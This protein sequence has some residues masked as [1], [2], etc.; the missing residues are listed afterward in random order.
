MSAKVEELI[1][2]IAT[3][4]RCEL[5]LRDTSIPLAPPGLHVPHTTA[6]PLEARLEVVLPPDM[7][8]FRE[9][10]KKANIF[11]H[12]VLGGALPELNGWDIWNVEYWGFDR[13]LGELFFYEPGDI[14]D[15]LGSCYR[16]ANSAKDGAHHIAVDLG[17]ERYGQII[18]CYSDQVTHGGNVPVIAKSF[19]EWLERTLDAGPLIT[20][21]YWEEPGF[22]D[23]GSA[24]DGDPCYER[25][26]I[27]PGGATARM[28]EYKSARTTGLVGGGEGDVTWIKWKRHGLPHQRDLVDHPGE[29]RLQRPVRDA[30][31]GA[32]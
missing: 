16:F 15:Q 29:N 10:V 9:R 3:D 22:D 1:E 32:L 24:L 7:F 5:E 4:S 30:V 11:A 26:P 17:A 19:S 13:L 8:Y 23:Y 28:M 27:L 14:W 20:N 2:R 12:A 31:G 18:E 21:G 25:R 6:G